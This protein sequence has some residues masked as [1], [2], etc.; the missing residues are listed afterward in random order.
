MVP[1]EHRRRTRPRVAERVGQA[2]GINH[3]GCLDEFEDRLLRSRDLIFPSIL[4]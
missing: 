4:D 3:P 1:E 2:R